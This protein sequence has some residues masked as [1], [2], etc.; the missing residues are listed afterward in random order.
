MATRTLAACNWSIVLAIVCAL[1]SPPVASA[2]T[3]VAHPSNCTN[4]ASAHE[5]VLAARVNQLQQELDQLKA[6]IQA[7]QAATRQAQTQAV[8]SQQAAN[9]AAK[10]S[11]QPAAPAFSSAA[12]I[13][14]TLHGFIDATAFH[15]S[16][17][18]M[19]GN[20]QNAELPVPGSHGSLSGFDVRNSRFWLDMTSARLGAGWTASGHL[21]MDFF[22][23][24]NGTG[25]VS[26]QQETPRLRQA[27]M[28]LDH[29]SS[30]T[31]IRIG[32]Q[33][34]LMAMLDTIPVSLSH[35]AFPLGFASGGWLGW[36][37]PGVVLLQDL[38]VGSS[39]PKWRLD[40]GAFDGNWSGP[41]DNVNW[42]T[43]GNAGFRPQIEAKLRV[44]DPKSEVTAYVAGHWSNIDLKGV[45]GAA[46]APVKSSFN[47]IS[48]DAGVAWKPSTFLIQAAAYAGRGMGLFFGNMAQFGDIRGIGGFAQVGDHFTPHWALY[49]FYGIAKPKTA[50]VVEW[51]GHGATGLLKSQQAALDLIYTTGP[52]DIGLE[53]MYDKLQSTPDGISRVNTDGNQLSLSAM[54]HF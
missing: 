16:T 4:G 37:Y 13:S 34:D 31:E 27:Y 38:N 49:G 7:Q 25:A 9:L 41:G 35:V 44:T 21:E 28:N 3:H 50:D 12:G 51:I 53:W 39:G 36:R 8:Q 6:E 52:V 40:I 15:Q 43:A 45:G 18:F 54:Y 23:G 30:G 33:W 47:S 2:K 29:A 17:P 20:G 24:F 22:G 10:A 11:P 32:Q 14:V 1:G 48:V 5:Q 26:R 19:F 46:S 42:L